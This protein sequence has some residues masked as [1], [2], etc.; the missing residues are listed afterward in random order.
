MLESGIGLYDIPRASSKIT[1]RSVSAP[2]DTSW[3]L[4]LFPLLVISDFRWIAAVQRNGFRIIFLV[5]VKK[6]VYAPLGPVATTD[7]EIN[8]QL[9]NLAIAPNGQHLV[10]YKASEK[11]FEWLKIDL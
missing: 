8:A 2:S 5:D 1:E 10:C 3:N 6:K 7:E 4:D 9:T 11:A